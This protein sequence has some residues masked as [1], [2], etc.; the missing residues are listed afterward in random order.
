MHAITR[1]INN[2]GPWRGQI[3]SLGISTT[4]A[5]DGSFGRRPRVNPRLH[6]SNSRSDNTDDSADLESLE[7]ITLV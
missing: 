7:I 4:E 1:R 2:N 6:F 5:R 3:G